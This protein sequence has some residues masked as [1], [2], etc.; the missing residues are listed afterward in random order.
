MLYPV[1]LQVGGKGEKR[2]YSFQ[3]IM[4]SVVFQ[5][6][7]FLGA[8]TINDGCEPKVVAELKVF[9]KVLDEGDMLG[10]VLF[11]DTAGGVYH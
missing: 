6:K 4:C 10:E 7:Q 3:G 8:V 11:P 1:Y 5:V 2:T 9:Y